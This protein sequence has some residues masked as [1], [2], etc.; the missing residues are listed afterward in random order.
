MLRYLS[1]FRGL[2]DLAPNILWFF[3]TATLW[4]LGVLI[5]DAYPWGSKGHEIV[6]AIA[7]PHLTD[8]ARKRIKELL[9]QGTTLADAST[10]P[11]KAGRQI[12]DMDVYHYINFPKDANTYHQERNCKLRNCVIEA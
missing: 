3:L 2:Y 7:E 1:P 5:S 8:T 12:P 11:D 10:W 4:L 6:A 9:P